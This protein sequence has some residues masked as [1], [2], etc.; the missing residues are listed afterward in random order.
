[1]NF[2]A[3]NTIIFDLDGTLVDLKKSTIYACFFALNQIYGSKLPKPVTKKRISKMVGRPIALQLSQLLNWNTETISQFT[4]HYNEGKSKFAHLNKLT[5][6]A[7]QTLKQLSKR[8]KILHLVTNKTRTET[9]KLLADFNLE[10]YFTR[11]IT[12]DD[13]F[14]NKTDAIET[15][16]TN[17]NSTAICG[18]MTSDVIDGMFF[19]RSQCVYSDIVKTIIKNLIS[20]TDGFIRD[21]FKTREKYKLDGFT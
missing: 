4:H 8:G 19:I 1:M 21:V 13:G 20:R 16:N 7:K 6:G 11:V 17:S 12:R 15:L 3:K 10:N 5:K 9:E 18:H 14:V 2:H